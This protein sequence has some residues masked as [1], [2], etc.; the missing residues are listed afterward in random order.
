MPPG[1]YVGD[2]AIG[3]QQITSLS[4]AVGLTVPAGASSAIIQAEAQSVRW[5]DDTV[6]PTS[7][8]GMV[9]ASGASITYTGGNLNTIKFI[10]TTAS[11]KLN[12]SFYR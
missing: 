4:S 3:Y 7:S 5:R 11:A 6:N 10:E 12:V 8:V 9:I 2:V 1:G